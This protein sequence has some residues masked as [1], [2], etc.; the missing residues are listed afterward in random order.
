MRAGA[1]RDTCR[2]IRDSRVRDT[3]VSSGRAYRVPSAV[4]ARR[5]NVSRRLKTR[6]RDMRR[7]REEP[8][9]G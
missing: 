8:T 3:S 2:L 9:Q 5:M 1:P 7:V 6:T 4:R